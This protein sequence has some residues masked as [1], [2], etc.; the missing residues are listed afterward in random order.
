MIKKV[1]KKAPVKGGFSYKKENV[2]KLIQ[3]RIDQLEQEKPVEWLGEEI[4]KLFVSGEVTDQDILELQ[5]KAVPMKDFIIITSY[6]TK[7]PETGMFYNEALEL[8]RRFHS[9]VLGYEN[10]L[11]KTQSRN[12]AGIGKSLRDYERR[13]EKSFRDYERIVDEIYNNTLE[14]TKLDFLKSL[15]SYKEISSEMG[16]KYYKKSP[17]YEI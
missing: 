10:E 17:F 3:L 9:I 1:S 4:Q 2:V 15:P 7:N 11:T 6:I 16:Y 12:E 5:A 13:I 8:A 14:K